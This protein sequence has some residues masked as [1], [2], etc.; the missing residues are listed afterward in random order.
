MRGVELSA[1]QEI[2]RPESYLAVARD[3]EMISDSRL[4]KGYAWPE[5]DPRLRDQPERQLGDEDARILSEA[6]V[7]TRFNW[8]SFHRGH[9]DLSVADRV[10]E[11]LNHRAFQFNSRAT[12]REF[13]LWRERIRRAVQAQRPVELLLP[14]FCVIA[15]PV[16][17]FQST[18][19][20]AAEDVA[21]LHLG[22]LAKLVAR[23]H[24][25][26]ATV[27]LIADSTFYSPPFGVSSVE[28]CTYIE[29]LRAR[30][31]SLRLTPVMRI[32]DMS[33]VLSA[34]MT[35]FQDRFH[36]WFQQLTADPLADGLSAAE[37]GR[38]VSSMTASVNTRRLGLSYPQMRSVFGDESPLS[39]P[40]RGAVEQQA[41]AALNEYR[42]IKA[43]AADLEWENLFFPGSVRATIHTK[44]VPVLGLRLY[45]EYKFSSTLLPYHGIGVLSR[46]SRTGTHR[47]TVR[48]E[49]FVAGDPEY[50]RVVNAEKVTLFYHQRADS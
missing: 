13:P 33:Q 45:P 7:T 36:H 35:D 29:L 6:A 11:L 42:A 10:L 19:V 4:S 43:A 50:T 46:S 25:P 9:R 48:P 38:W 39:E 8:D 30:I 3:G 18:V 12:Y 17:R 40:L 24:P 26:G 28:A 31:R 47:L 14:V 5:S 37:H 15:N 32:H 16:K 44:K 20:T 49:M 2:G 23:I 22:E 27:H 1:V 34:R 41:R 21:L